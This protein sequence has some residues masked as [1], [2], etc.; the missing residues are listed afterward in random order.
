MTI[1]QS[2]MAQKKT[3]LPSRL[4]QLLRDANVVD[5]EVSDIKKKLQERTTAQMLS[6]LQ[7]VYINLHHESII[8][9][10]FFEQ[11][12]AHGKRNEYLE[13]LGTRACIL[14]N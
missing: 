7:L 4:T 11:M 10:S 6:Y 14:K 1:L 9:R 13:L 12:D 2:R 3:P 5:T 8:D